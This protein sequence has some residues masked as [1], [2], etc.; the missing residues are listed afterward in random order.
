M[1][2]YLGLDLGINSIGWVLVDNQELKS[3]GVRRI[4]SSQRL[5]KR[6]F[7]RKYQRGLAKI[8]K[9]F[10]SKLRTLFTKNYR[11]TLLSIL[12]FVLFLFSFIFFEYWQLF[13]NLGIGGLISILSVEKKV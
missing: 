11:L 2:K 1:C 3:Y 4:K 13:L 5:E 7:R 12:T 10:S 9:A 6:N 8:K